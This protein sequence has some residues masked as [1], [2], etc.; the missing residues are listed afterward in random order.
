MMPQP[1]LNAK[2][3]R[4]RLRLETLN[5]P[6]DDGQAVGEANARPRSGP[7]SKTMRSRLRIRHRPRRSW[8]PT[9]GLAGKPSAN[10]Y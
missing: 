1:K 3:K 5:K 4:Q 9:V 8:N 2:A 7:I 6:K 10:F